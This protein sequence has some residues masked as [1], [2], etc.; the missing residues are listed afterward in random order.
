M[1]NIKFKI[2]ISLIS[3]CLGA[4]V[5]GQNDFCEF[6]QLPEDGWPYGDT[7]RFSPVFADS[8]STAIPVIAIRHNNAYAYSNLW[9]ELSRMS[10][11]SSV[12]ILDTINVRL[13]DIYGRWQ[14]HGFGASYQHADTLFTAT[15]VRSGESVAV[16]H[17]MRVDTLRDIEQLGILFVSTK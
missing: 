5:P 15:P 12:M 17:I 1:T 11:D 9:L 2:L 6:R 16:R 13:A 4:C 10:P 14:G 7:L 3:L 8:T